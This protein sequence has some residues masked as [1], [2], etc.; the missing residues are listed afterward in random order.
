M[1]RAV[2]HVPGRGLDAGS[3]TALVRR[4]VRR[5]G[6]AGLVF[7]GVASALVVTAVVSARLTGDVPPHFHHFVLAQGA[8]LALSLA[9]AGAARWSG[10]APRATLE[11]GRAYQVAGALTISVCAFYGDMLLQPVM[12][13]VSWLAVW[14]LLFAFL[15]PGRP[16]PSVATALLCA[17]TAP[18]VFLAWAAHT[19]APVPR[20][21]VLVHTFLPYYVCAGLTALPALVL[22]DLGQVAET[23]QREARRLGSYRLVERLGVGGMGEVWRAE[24]DL[25]ARRAAIKLIKPD[26]LT[27][28]GPDEQRDAVARFEQEA[29]VLATLS[30]PHTVSVFDFGVGAD[31]ALFFVMELL[32]GMDLEVLV[33]RFG[34]LSP[35]RAVYLLAQVCDSLA[36]AH[37]AGLVHRDVKPA[38]LVLCRVG[39]QFDF[40]KVLDFGLVASRRPGG[41]KITSDDAIV[42]T[43][44]YLSP[45]LAGGRP[46]DGRSDLYQL[47]CVAYYLLTG[48]LVFEDPSPGRLVAD[49]ITTRPTPPSERASQPISP[50]LEALVMRCLEK[51]PTRRFESAES[52]GRALRA[53][54]EFAGWNNDHARLWWMV[55]LPGPARAE[56]ARE[57]RAT[58]SGWLDLA[59]GP[60]AV[61]PGNATETGRPIATH[62][63]EDVVGQDSAGAE[64]RVAP[65][66]ASPAS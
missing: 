30:S 32:D 51:D 9:M 24:H 45:E 7:A 34:A 22:Q 25:L 66:H 61:P 11:L 40:V 65:E 42:G 64:P 31:G 21:S 52:L 4:A 46:L 26:R 62:R 2:V 56:E 10:L 5:L 6:V 54:P 58:S 49:H 33:Q 41:G 29:R 35:A 18:V 15:V 55:Q 43:P 38:N 48:K 53:L 19:G 17:T 20:A 14:I 36:E 57:R 28:G 16:L 13:K 60:G 27:R 23:A 12:V 3:S 1:T 50:A 63:S 8:L 47:G 39:L 44:A 37:E 59:A